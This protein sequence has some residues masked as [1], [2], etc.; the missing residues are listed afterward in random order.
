MNKVE[1][2]IKD[3]IA[4]KTIEESREYQNKS[5]CEKEKYRLKYDEDAKYYSQLG[6]DDETSLHADVIVS[7]WTIYKT[8]LRN[9]VNWNA[10][11]SLASLKALDRQIEDE[12]LYQHQKI[13]EV[14]KM[15]LPFA[16][17]CYT[18]GNYMLLPKG[19]REMNAARYRL[20][21]DR[22]DATL[23]QCFGKGKLSV[24]FGSDDE[25][26]KWILSQKL[27]LMFI[28]EDISPNKLRWLTNSAKEKLITEM[29]TKELLEYINNAIDF[30]KERD[31][32]L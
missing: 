29:S 25:V 16:E 10:S 8:L 22:I 24:F 19:Q 27:Q 9:E 11:K 13:N 5:V 1:K 31:K 2:I 6:L 12:N 23:F 3:Y 28:D 14:N 26:R 7:F 18:K 21:E 17:V 32:L 4:W 20:T 30:I 15:I